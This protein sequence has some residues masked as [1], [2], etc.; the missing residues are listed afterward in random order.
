MRIDEFLAQHAQEPGGPTFQLES[1][2][3]LEIKVDGTVWAK[4]GSMVA[5]NGEL[6]FKRRTGGIGKMLKKALTGEGSQTMQVEGVGMLYLADQAKEI[7]VLQLAEGEAVSV[8]GNDVLA[9]E[10]S[11]T[12]K[13]KMM[14][15]VAGWA[16]GGLF[17]MELNGPGMIAFTT[18]GNPLVLRTPVMTDPQATVAWSATTQPSF[19]TDLN[20]GSFIGRSSGETFQ[21]NFAQEGGFVVVQPYEEG[22][23]SPG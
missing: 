16:S 6:K 18:H 13:I 4:A 15:K 17:N 7:H 22:G 1:S 19:K 3:M 20:L 23:A 9:F 2:K 12:W 11:I 21:M 8:N 14:K 10:S 5:Y